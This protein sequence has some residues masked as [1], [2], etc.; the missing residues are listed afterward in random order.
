MSSSHPI[1]PLLRLRT[2]SCGVLLA[3]SSFAAT[4]SAS[5]AGYTAAADCPALDVAPTAGNA[6]EIRAAVLCLTNAE[7]GQRDLRP[8]RENAKL[9]RAALVHSAHM[10]RHGYFAHTTPDG[11]TFVDRIV[12]AGYARRYDGWSLGENLA[13]G[14]GN[15]GT[16]RAIHAAWMR[17]SGHRSNILEASYRELGIGVRAGVPANADVGATIT[18]DFGATA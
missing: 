8:L 5:A 3:A 16:A 10:V 7:R 15:R 14:T 13:W 17:S 1:R 9:R 6:D 12:D 18:T 2:L 4:A 11:D